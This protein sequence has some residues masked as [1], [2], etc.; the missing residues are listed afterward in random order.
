MTQYV[1]IVLEIED[2]SKFNVGFKDKIHGGK[3]TA[4]AKFDAIN[5]V[6]VTER[7]LGESDWLE[8]VEALEEIKEKTGI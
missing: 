8:C 6:D 3:V 2:M 7:V 4:M 5:Y 1:T